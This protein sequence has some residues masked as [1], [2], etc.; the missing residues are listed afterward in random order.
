MLRER[1][2]SLRIREAH[3]FWKQRGMRK[4]SLDKN[5][6]QTSKV[7]CQTGKKDWM[8]VKVF[9]VPWYL[10][11]YHFY[12]SC[13]VSANVYLPILPFYLSMVSGV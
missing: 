12:T 5:Q 9:V 8:K 4:E 13:I 11:V 10:V 3:N 1:W 6:N 7:N 2:Q